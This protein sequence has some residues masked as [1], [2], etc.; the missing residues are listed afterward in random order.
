[1]NVFERT[2]RRID[3]FQQHHV[4]PSFVMGVIKKYGDNNGGNLAVQLT[5]AMFMTVFPLLLLL[6]TILSI[7]L[8]GEPSWRARVLN[9][10][11]GEF[12]VV[13]QQFAHNIHA[14]KRS[15]AFGLVVGILGLI[16]GTTRLA[17]SGL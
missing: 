5:Y 14:L 17:Q 16:Y 15:S 2:F 6:I 9:S 11:F 10:A 3:E 7:V 12:P 4:V 1:M 8:A 13:G